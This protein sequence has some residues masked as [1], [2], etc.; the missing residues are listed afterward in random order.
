[1]ERGA[2]ETAGKVYAP[3]IAGAS[4][5]AGLRL[6]S[7]DLR[8]QA[9]EGDVLVLDVRNELYLEVNRSGALLW[10]LLA[11]GTS[12]TELVDR[13]VRVYDLPAERAEADV[14]CLLEELSA[15]DLLERPAG[16]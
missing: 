16:R 2:V 7:A 5:S 3:L 10:E 12:R 4:A 15:R 14:D 6:R 1:M 8:W 9:V 13:L 11:R